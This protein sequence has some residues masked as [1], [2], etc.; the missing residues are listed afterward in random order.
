MKKK[1][2]QK[3]SV[4]FNVN[5]F[6]AALFITIL[7][8]FS[9]ISIKKLY[10]FYVYDI[11][12]YNE[13]SVDSGTKL[14]TDFITNFFGKIQFVNFNGA[15][16]SLLNQREMNQIVKL[17]NGYLAKPI[18]KISEDILKSNAEEIYELQKQLLME[19][20]P[21]LYVITPYSISKYDPQLPA[22]IDDYGNA[23]M[24]VFL[25]YLD[26][27]NVDYMDL[28]KEIYLDG[29]NQYDLWYKTDHHWTTEGGFY[30]YTK[31]TERLESILDV[32]VDETLKNRDNYSVTTYKN[33]HLGSNGQRTGIY[34]AGIDDF[35]LILPEFDTHI[36]DIEGHTGTLEEL[37][38]DY[39][40]LKNR[41]YESRYTYDYVLRK[42]LGRFE[43]LY[44][45]NDKKILIVCDSMGKSVNPFLA[46]S[47]QEIYTVSAS[48]LTEELIKSYQPDVVLLLYYAGQLGSSDS[49]YKF[50]L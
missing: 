16:R 44:A 34:Y 6:H 9:S 13:W 17:N 37:L 46:I 1:V 3:K 39:Q 15:V 8:V 5:K 28:R 10:N 45:K 48:K 24:D 4:F 31:I 27:R 19:E 7:A 26:K 22:G 30:A 29:I 18:G 32:S 23:N 35:D 14:E 33:W 40:P 20:I 21:L 2:N 43:N 12:D 41:D 47:F 11:T 36:R 42:S 38:I 49:Y 50:G 25:S